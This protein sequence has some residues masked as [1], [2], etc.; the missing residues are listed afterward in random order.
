MRTKEQIAAYMREYNQRTE[1]KEMKRERDRKQY[2]KNKSLFL[3]RSRRY[4][5]ENREKRLSS[6]ARYRSENNDRI[7]ARH[8]N[9]REVNRAE[10]KIRR[11]QLANGFTEELFQRLV[12]EQEG[13][14]W[15]CRKDLNF[16][17]APRN[18]SATACADHCHRTGKP[19]GILCVPCNSMLGFAHDSIEILK[20]AI[21]YL[22]KHKGRN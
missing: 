8:R 21:L 3:A 16:D 19:R 2:A 1:V 15:I 6:Q 10:I 22:E 12:N 17:H 7:I 18:N 20:K 11:R 4:Y 14:C 9:Y 13:Q 5:K